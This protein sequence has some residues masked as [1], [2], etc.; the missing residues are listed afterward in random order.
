MNLLPFE[1]LAGTSRELGLVVG[2]GVGFAFGF[3]LERAGFGRA[4]KLVGQFYGD[5]MTVFKVMF[6]AIVTAMLGVVA[7]GG[8]GVVDLRALSESAA[9]AT[10]LWPMLVGGL[11]LGAGFIVSGYCPGTSVVATASGKLDGLAT[12]AG[13][14]VGSVLYAE[15]QPRLGGFHTSGDLGHRFLYELV[16]LPPAVLALGITAFAV[17]AFLG[18]EW[19]ERRVGGAGT[20]A[21][22]RRRRAVVFA[23]LGTTA[24]LALLTLL[25]PA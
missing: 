12:V 24:A 18:A 17:V 16:G 11:L 3:V 13:V 10:Y 4:Q 19:V 25:V 7:L 15:V 6:T 21:P 14:V 1:S 2:V 8:L 5:D 20:P 22:E 23:G 9:S